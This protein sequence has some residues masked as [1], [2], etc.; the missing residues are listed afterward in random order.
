MAGTIIISSL[1]ETCIWLGHSGSPSPRL[2]IKFNGH[3]Y[4]NSGGRLAYNSAKPQCGII[5]NALTIEARMVRPC[6]PICATMRT[7]TPIGKLNLSMTME[8]DNER[9]AFGEKGG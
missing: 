9:N 8:A 7:S 6:H 3:V 2:A 5:W 1:D 4:C